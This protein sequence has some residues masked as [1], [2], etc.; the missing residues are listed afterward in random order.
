MTNM[1]SVPVVIDALGGN[2]A[3]AELT[4]TTGKVV[5]HWRSTKRFPA[6]SYVTLKNKLHEMGLSAPD[7]LWAMRKA[8]HPAKRPG[9]RKAIKA[10]IKRRVAKRKA[11]RKAKR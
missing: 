9:L 10:V 1:P 8:K 2:Q 4:H 7:E 11:K 6:N 3:V 5:S